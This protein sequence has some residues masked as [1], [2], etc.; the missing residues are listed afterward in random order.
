M[1]Y[2][3]YNQTSNMKKIYVYGQDAR[4]LVE[5][6]IFRAVKNVITEG[7]RM[8]LVP[9]VLIDKDYCPSYEVRSS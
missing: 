5:G 2:I 9:V 6:Q 4:D 7:D 8:E 1:V 3:R